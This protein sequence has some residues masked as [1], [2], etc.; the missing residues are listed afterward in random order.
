MWER[1]ILDSANIHFRISS[2]AHESSDGLLA[3]ALG[4][5][6]ECETMLPLIQRDTKK[7]E[8]ISFLKECKVGTSKTVT[9]GHS[10]SFQISLFLCPPPFYFLFLS[11]LFSL[12]GFV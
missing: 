2:S 7:K 10:L 1:E 11:F 5:I 3:A 6:Y 12:M 8:I 9:F 4:Y